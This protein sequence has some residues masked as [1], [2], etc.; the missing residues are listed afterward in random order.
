MPS[1]IILESSFFMPSLTDL[2]FSKAEEDL[3]F[4]KRSCLEFRGGEDE[5]LKRLIDFIWNVKAINNYKKK[6]N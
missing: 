1:E 2:G 4:D 3:S 5:G 6:R